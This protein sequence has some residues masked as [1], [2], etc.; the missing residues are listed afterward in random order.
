MPGLFASPPGPTSQQKALTTA[1]TNAATFGLNQAESTLPQATSILQQPLQFFQSLLSG[2]RQD[3][4]SAIQPAVSSLTSQYETAKRTNNEFAPRGGGAT[5]ANAEAPYKEAG[6]ISSLVFQ[7][8]QA[9]AA[10][11]TQ[12]GSLLADL[13]LG[14]MG[15]AGNIALGAS[16][17]LL[18][19]QELKTQQQQQLQ[20]GVGSAIGS[21]VSLLATA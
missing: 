10:G 7:G 19:A 9:G 21:L 3:I 2:N 17:N 1:E 20:T 5:A 12:I 18:S 15:T 11:V 6:D 8:Q 4:M 13:G 16:S 14:E